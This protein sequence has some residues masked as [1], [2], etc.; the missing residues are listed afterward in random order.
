MDCDACETEIFYDE[1]DKH[2]KMRVW[3]SHW[4]DRIDDYDYTDIKIKYCYE[5][6]K[7]Y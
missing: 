4:D 2:W 1:W 6:G 7:K 3:N 5:C